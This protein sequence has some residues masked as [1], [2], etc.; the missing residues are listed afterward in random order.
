MSRFTAGGLV[1]ALISSAILAALTSQVATA[2]DGSNAAL[3][4]DRAF[5]QDVAK[6]SRSVVSGLLDADFT[7]T[8]ANGKTFTRAQVLADI[9][10]PSISDESSAQITD[11]NYGEVELIQAR[12]GRANILRI[13][14]ERPGGWRLLVYQEAT[15]LTGTPTPVAGSAQSCVN[16]CK[17]LPYKAKNEMERGVLDGYMA[18][19]TATVE[20]NS[21]E[22]GKYVA[23]EFSAASSNSGKI[24]D[25]P[26][27]MADLDRSK[28]AG[29]APM[30][31]VSLRLFDFSN[32]AVLISKH[33]PAHGKP[34]HITRLWIKRDGHWQEAVSYQTRMQGARAQ[35]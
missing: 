4:A 21:A 8:D 27:R 5:V 35:P 32:A 31:V 14:V 17:T 19:Q 22:W 18:L 11:R 1:L 24:L 30:P 3:L 33:Q 10:K 13:W 34:F 16:P 12:S 28:M 20:R 26:T 29:Y 2:A 15:L 23:D 7:W 6:D 9:P 25:K